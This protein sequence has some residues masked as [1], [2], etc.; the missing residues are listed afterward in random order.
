MADTPRE[1]VGMLRDDCERLLREAYLRGAEWHKINGMDIGYLAKAAGDYA[2]A[3]MTVT[4][5]PPETPIKPA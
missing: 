4:F 5:G 1:T 2:D 3:T